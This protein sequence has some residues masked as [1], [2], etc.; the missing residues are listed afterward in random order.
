MQP[1]AREFAGV[2]VFKTNPATPESEFER[3]LA[4]AIRQRKQTGEW[5]NV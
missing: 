4:S 3:R 5:Q 1:A 2:T